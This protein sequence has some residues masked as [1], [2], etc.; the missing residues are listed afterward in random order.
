MDDKRHAPTPG[1]ELHG[2][3]EA[4]IA[5]YREDTRGHHI[6]KRFT[7]SRQE[8][9]DIVDLLLQIFYPGYNGRQDLSD[10]DLLYHVGTLVSTLQTKLERQIERCLCFQDETVAGCRIDIP[11]CRQR[12][13]DVAHAFVGKLPE[14]RRRLLLD[15]QAAYDGDPAASSMDEII[16]AYPGLLAVTVYRVA[17]ELYLLGVPLMPR[18]MSE[19]AHTRTGADIHPGA[20]IG[21][22]F[23]I[24][25]ATGVVIGETTDI[26]AHVKL[27]QGVT[28]GALSLP[29]HSRGARGLKRHPTVEDHVT[30]YANAT[31]LGGKTVL[32]QGSVVGG[33]VFLTKSVA[34]GQRVAI[35]APR[36]RVASPPQGSPTAGGS[37]AEP[38]GILD[39]DI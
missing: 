6:N 3:V 9:I 19:W 35:E 11:K 1:S 20:N 31:V 15:V 18:I 17:H 36:L 39:F 12:G 22:S 16:L 28:L 24:D 32:G 4:L 38:D 8:I 21:D 33:S 10:E 29:Q 30:I 7:P 5:G 14:I 34:D 23:F 2:V 37:E 26:G 27:Y 13:R 25:H